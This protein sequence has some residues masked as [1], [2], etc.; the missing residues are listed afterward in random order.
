MFP[1]ICLFVELSKSNSSS[2]L[3][4]R[5]TTRVS[6]GWAASISMRFAI[7]SN[8]E[9]RQRLRYRAGGRRC[10]KG[11]EAR[12]VSGRSGMED[13]SNGHRGPVRDAR[14]REDKGFG[15]HPTV[16]RERRGGEA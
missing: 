15:V 6:S 12:G 5:T 11:C 14:I 3:P 7:A 9:E 8:S 16:S 13:K 1:L 4:L 10:S 2:L